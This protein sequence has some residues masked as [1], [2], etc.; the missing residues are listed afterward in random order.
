MDAGDQIVHRFPY[1]QIQH[2]AVQGGV[3]A[4]GTAKTDDLAIGQA[5]LTGSLCRVHHFGSLHLDDIQVD[6]GVGD[7]LLAAPEDAEQL[8]V[9]HLLAP[10]L[11]DIAG[12]HEIG[13]LDGLRLFLEARF[14]ADLGH[15]VAIQHIETAGLL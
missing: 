1:R 10:E 8:M 14:L 5:V 6:L 9:A 12:D 11:G 7:L 13:T 3:V 15:I 2:L 4:G